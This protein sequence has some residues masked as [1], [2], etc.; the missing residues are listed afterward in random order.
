MIFKIR[1]TS[2]DFEAKTAPCEGAYLDKT[3]KHNDYTEHVWKIKV[4][5]I[6]ELMQL[7]EKTREPLIIFGKKNEDEPMIE[8]YDDYRE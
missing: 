3:I 2:A 4:N 7:I 1:R 5:T 8:I 6:K